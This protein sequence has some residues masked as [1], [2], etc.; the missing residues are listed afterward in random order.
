MPNLII[1]FQYVQLIVLQLYIA[2]K[3]KKKENV[4]V[5]CHCA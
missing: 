4:K 5:E 2:Y 1:H 3:D